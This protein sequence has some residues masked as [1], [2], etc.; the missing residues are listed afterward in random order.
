MIVLILLSKTFFGQ[1]NYEVLKKIDSLYK[2]EDYKTIINNNILKI[3]NKKNKAE[4]LTIL[5]SSYYNLNIEDSAFHYHKKA[6]KIYKE[7]ND[8]ENIAKINFEIFK[9]LDSQNN[10]ESD[11]DYYLNELNLYA[12]KTN[13]KKWK[14]TVNHRF[15]L[16]HYELNNLD[17]AKFYLNKTLNQFKEID[18]TSM[19]IRLLSDLGS[20][21][22][23]KLKKHDSAVLFYEN[24]IKILNT[25]S[26]IKLDLNLK[27]DL[28]NNMGNVYKRKKD[29][30]KA[31]EY[32]KYI[33]PIE[34]PKLNRKSKKIL[35]ENMSATY[36]YMNDFENAYNYLYNYDSIKDSIQLQK[37]NA[38]ISDISQKY[39]NEKL[40]AD[41][42]ELENKRKKNQ[43]LLI[44]TLIVLFFGGITAF[45][46]QKNTK[47]KQ[48][49]AEQGKKLQTQKVATLMKEQELTSI[50]AMIEGQEKERQQIANDLHD[51]L[52][53]LMATVKLHFN[54]LEK[55]QSPELFSKTNNL[56]EEAYQKI[57][58]VAH[59]KNSGVL[60]KKG[61]LKAINDMANKVSSAN[62]L[63]IEVIDHG[64][65][66]RLENSL[67]LTIFRITQE[68][69]TNVI[70]HAN[71]TE[72]SIQIT[73]HED[74]L[75]IIVEDNGK[76]FD[77][78]HISKSSGMG[79][80]SIDKRIENLEGTVVIDSK[81][82]KGTTVIIDIPL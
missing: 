60:A 1:D 42:L 79:I 56:L 41:G 46:L 39:D 15:G 6:L 30:K 5:A 44:A 53:G 73:N 74:K 25:D 18:S 76:G 64:L 40:R 70:K 54:A 82:N 72:A 3:S 52:G 68:L 43:N 55:K 20:L 80:H 65:E 11:K 33:E 22:S 81:I 2:Q 9:L 34:L 48:L 17:S 51:D 61:L 66:N 37:Q 21:Y 26:V 35:Y 28:Y 49:L 24:A 63:Q 27:H 59:A 32:Y 19:Q 47:R 62:K 77:T 67:E 36:Y 13:S 69:I 45:L 16:K 57:R 4:Y 29:Y 7:I 12:N 14:A 78:K 50:D 31:L 38:L 10:L 58:T 8:S 23:Y 71:A 75:N